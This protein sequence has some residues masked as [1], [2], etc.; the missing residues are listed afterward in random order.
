MLSHRADCWMTC[1]NK[2]DYVLTFL[3]S[4]AM[5][6]IF[7]FAWSGESFVTFVASVASLTLGGVDAR[8]RDSR[9]AC[10]C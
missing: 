7:E 2:E 6:M 9:I 5:F 4:V 1:S 10:A 3:A 8:L